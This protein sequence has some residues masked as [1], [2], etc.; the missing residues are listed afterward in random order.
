MQFSLLRLVSALTICCLGFGAFG[1]FRR[2]VA[3]EIALQGLILGFC[4]LWTDWSRLFFRLT[5]LGWAL[6]SGVGGPHVAS[7]LIDVFPLI[8]V[9]PMAALCWI[10]LVIAGFA[11]VPWSRSPSVEHVKVVVG[12]SCLF[13]IWGA[14]VLRSDYMIQI[15]HSNCLLL[16]SVVVCLVSEYG[17]LSRTSL[18]ESPR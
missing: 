7:R 9:E 4:V 17:A 16:F 10:L 6:T 3:M 5:G 13:V 11:L 8:S 15:Y 12:V 2:D 18:H 1:I 14:L